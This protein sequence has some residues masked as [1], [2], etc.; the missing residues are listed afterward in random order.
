MSGNIYP[1]NNVVGHPRH[2]IGRFWPVFEW[3]EQ[4]RKRWHQRSIDNMPECLQCKYALLCG[5]GCLYGA[6]VDNGNLYAP[7][8]DDFP[9]T[10][11]ALILSYYQQYYPQ[12]R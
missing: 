12:V 6:L 10:F 2:A 3:D 4:E 11:K 8:C 1:C 7:H 5:G 9:N